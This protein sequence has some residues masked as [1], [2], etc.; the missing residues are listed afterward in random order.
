M[1]Y[2]FIIILALLLAS[3]NGDKNKIKEHYQNTLR[4]PESLKIYS[5]ELIEYSGH[6]NDN[7][8]YKVDY[9]AKNGYGGMD[10]HTDYIIFYKGVIKEVRN[11][12]DVPE[13]IE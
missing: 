5:I 3:C 10:R 2:Y 11:D 13:V 1:K 4:D 9:G 6:N 12:F 7:K 8:K